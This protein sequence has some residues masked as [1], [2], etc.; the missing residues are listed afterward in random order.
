MIE[1]GS[2]ISL[3][4]SYWRYFCA[5][6]IGWSFSHVP[7]R[8]VFHRRSVWAGLVSSLQR[9]KM[10]KKKKLT[11]QGVTRNAHFDD[12]HKDQCL[13]K[14]VEH[15]GF[16][17]GKKS[18]PNNKLWIKVWLPQTLKNHF[19]SNRADRE[20]LYNS[21][22]TRHHLIVHFK[23]MN[24]MICGLC[25]GKVLFEKKY[26]NCHQEYWHSCHIKFPIFELFVSLRSVW[27]SAVLSSTEGWLLLLS[28]ICISWEDDDKKSGSEVE[29]SA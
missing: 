26:H 3:H 20:E 8:C 17:F 5:S 11:F 28:T 13:R 12:F 15:S 24:F 2:L 16:D 7:H 25:L 23:R 10:K 4:V 27:I 1:T 6:R 21:E 14:L 22:Y 29:W 18:W 19:P 9:K